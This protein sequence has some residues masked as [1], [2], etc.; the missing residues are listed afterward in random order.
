MAVPFIIAS[1]FLED[2][3]YSNLGPIGDWLAGSS[4]PFFTLASLLILFA[5][6][7]TQRKELKETQEIVEKQFKLVSVQQFESTL[8]NLINMFQEITQS[9]TLMTITVTGGE[10]HRKGKECFYGFYQKLKEEINNVNSSNDLKEL[11][12]AYEKF[13]EKYEDK[14]GHYFRTMYRIYKFLDANHEL[15]EKEKNDYSDL[16][17]AQLSTYEEILIL[18]NILSPYGEKFIQ[19][20]EKYELLDGLKENHKSLEQKEHLLLYENLI[21]E[22]LN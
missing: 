4:T 22:K 1:I 18:Y 7:H 14:L 2:S 9:M 21:K 15:S 16:I 20:V 11:Q 8:F 19:Y 10:R 12:D 5:T 17:R 6:Y 3:N 13:Y